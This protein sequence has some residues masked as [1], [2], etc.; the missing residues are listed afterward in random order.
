MVYRIVARSGMSTLPALSSRSPTCS[1]SPS[2]IGE[3]TEHQG[4]TAPDGTPRDGRWTHI[5]F[6][7]VLAR[8]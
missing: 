3:F 4:G 7:L 2:L 5:D 6:D 8:L 1:R